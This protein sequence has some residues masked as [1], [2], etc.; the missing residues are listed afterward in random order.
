MPH[1]FLQERESEADWQPDALEL[2]LVEPWPRP[3][4]PT[5][6]EIDAPESEQRGSHVIIIDLA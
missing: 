2:P 5:T 6:I 3:L 4:S 1:S